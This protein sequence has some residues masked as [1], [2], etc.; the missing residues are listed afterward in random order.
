M[1]LNEYIDHTK[2]GPIVSKEDIDKLTQEAIEYSFKSVCVSPV[3]VSYAASLLKGKSPLVC[4][5]IGFPHGTHTK[6]VKA[7]ETADA[8]KNGADEIDMVV[9]VALVKAHDAK[10]IFED[11][12]SV[13]KAAS[14]KTVKVII[15]T[16]YLSK[17]EIIL[18]CEQAVKAKANFVKTSTGYASSGATKDDVALM[19]EIVKDHA[20]VKASGGVRTFEDA[21]IMINA[22]ASRIGTS[23][24][25]ALVNH[26]E[27]TSGY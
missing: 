27:A 1:K 16:A 18:V 23:N 26:K 22:G 4:T 2:L 5:V 7:Y 10:G 9:N 20:F 13:V 21:M 25:V 12:S 24:G 11:I 6:E 8:I 14:G 17:E 19:K 15:E 3:W